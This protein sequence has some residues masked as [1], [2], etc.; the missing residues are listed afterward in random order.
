MHLF[1]RVV[2]VLKVLVNF[3]PMVLEILLS[4]ITNAVILTMD[5][6]F[7]LLKSEELLDICKT[8][9]LML[10]LLMALNYLVIEDMIN[11]MEFNK[12]AR[13]PDPQRLIDG[14]EQSAAT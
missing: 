13:Q 12:T 5:H 8:R 9:H 6:L 11:D 4:F 10:K 3:Q 14:Y 7:Q 2:I 1:C